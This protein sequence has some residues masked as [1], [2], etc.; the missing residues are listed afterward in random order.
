MMYILHPTADDY[1][2]IS[3]SWEP[4]G[5]EES[6]FPKSDKKPQDFSTPGG[7]VCNIEIMKFFGAGRTTMFTLDEAIPALFISGSGVAIGRS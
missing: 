5:N 2:C 7:Q 6:S 3:L 1:R 4:T